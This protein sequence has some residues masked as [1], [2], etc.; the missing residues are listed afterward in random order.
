MILANA[1]ECPSCG[2]LVTETI[3]LPD[4]HARWT[5]M[6]EEENARDE[7]IDPSELAGEDVIPD[8]NH[9]S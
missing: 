5:K 6:R 1:K 7:E 9:A 3:T 8:R 4:L 2:G